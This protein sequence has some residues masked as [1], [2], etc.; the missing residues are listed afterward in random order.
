MKK[1]L[2]ILLALIPL[3][4][5]GQKIVINPWNNWFYHDTIV[6]ECTVIGGVDTTMY[7]LTDQAC[8]PA[9]YSGH[10]YPGTDSLNYS[11]ITYCN[12]L[13]GGTG[14]TSAPTI[15]FYGPAGG[16]GATAT[17]T[18]SGGSVTGI[19]ITAQGSGY[20]GGAYTRIT[21]GA[22]SGA[23]AFANVDRSSAYEE[24]NQATR[25]PISEAVD[26]GATYQLDSCAVWSMTGTPT[27][28]LDYSTDGVTWTNLFAGY[29][30]SIKTWHYWTFS[31]TGR[32]LRF[33]LQAGANIAQIV[34]Y[35]H[36]LSGQTLPATS[37]FGTIP[38]YTDTTFGMKSGFV[39]YITN[40]PVMTNQGYL[41]HYIRD[42]E[43]W[44]R[45]DTNGMW[46]SGS[47]SYNHTISSMKFV[48]DYYSQST[49]LYHYYLWN[50]ANGITTYQFYVN[51]FDSSYNY[52]ARNDQVRFY[53]FQ[54]TSVNVG[55][56][57]FAGQYP[58]TMP[59]DSLQS[60]LYSDNPDS[61]N[62]YNRL[63]VNAYN[64]AGTT[65][66]GST[67]YTTAQVS[68]P[69]P[70]TY[71][72]NGAATIYET[73]NETEGSSGLYQ[74][75][76]MWA[77]ERELYDGEGQT[78]AGFKT[79]F[80]AAQIMHFGTP[81]QDSGLYKAELYYS[82]HWTADG[83]IPED[84]SNFHMYLEDG[85]RG[86]SPE[87]PEVNGQDMYQIDTNWV[88][89]MHM[90]YPGHKTAKTEFGWDRN[91]RSKYG[92]AT[93]PGSDSATTQ[94]EW[95]T[96][97]MVID[98]FTGINIFTYYADRNDLLSVPCIS[99]GNWDST[100][101]YGFNTVGYWTLFENTSYDNYLMAMP[102]YWYIRS[103]DSLLFNFKA[104]SM[105]RFHNLDSIEVVRFK[106]ATHPDSVIYA[107][108]SGTK[109]GKT[110]S[111]LLV[112]LT[113]VAAGSNI[114]TVQM[115]N[116]SATGNITNTTADGSGNYTIPTLSENPVYIVAV[117]SSYVP[118]PFIKY[119]TPIYIKVIVK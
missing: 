26:L 55:S 48:E 31:A 42:Y 76:W 6:P 61:P 27:F 45:I 28:T 38:T 34:M 22:G 15:S 119:T 105:I 37:P 86:L 89:L 91:G 46:H 70:A 21:G 116:N 10:F 16:S 78:G 64:V 51:T 118:P 92:V 114:S 107:C 62:A 99:C 111:N 100:G 81:F 82:R 102:I 41:G 29:P 14:Y 94:A 69:A 13:N 18:I 65:G 113:G 50:I 33:T 43:G 68:Y 7:R 117:K 98:M 12:V 25:Y 5:Q 35:G 53:A 47:Q 79:A 30:P 112:P 9:N 20:Y 84:I 3:L 75:G 49:T 52:A 19:T 58:G 63:A 39:D 93:I 74:Y 80:P 77:M 66:G 2:S 40:S 17:A 103:Q 109:T 23:S 67:S 88:H 54:P 11:Q 110:V 95:A 106:S 90:Y 60:P 87:E 97:A 104:D 4:S 44:G 24:Y 57:C 85:I 8:D 71:W 32:Y 96:R 73:G 108:W 1:L 36:I 56:V 115:T 101:I 59:I 83:V 72:N